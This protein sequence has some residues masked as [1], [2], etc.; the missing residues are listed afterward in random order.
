MRCGTVFEAGD[1]VLLPL[2]FSDLT[3]SKRRP[4]L[5][6]TAPDAQGDFVGC[7]VTSR[8]GWNPRPPTFT[9]DLAKGALP[10]LSW[11]RADKFV[12][13]HTGLIARRFG[14]VTPEL[15]A[16]V[17]GDVCRFIDAPPA[18]KKP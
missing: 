17:A 1:L 11:V 7:P 13:P 8:A 15:R 18:A 16:A 6:L 5:M 2:P 9:G 14:Q 10:Q 3:S 12:T 4:V